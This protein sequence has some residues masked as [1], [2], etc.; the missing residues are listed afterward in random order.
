M[1]ADKKTADQPAS[2][3]DQHR[4]FTPHTPF[5]LPKGA[6]HIRCAKAPSAGRLS[7]K[8]DL[9]IP[10]FVL[11]AILAYFALN[12]SNSQLAEPTYLNRSP[13]SRTSGP[14]LCRSS[15]SSRSWPSS[16][17]KYSLAKRM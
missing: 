14:R 8:P 10:H 12:T 1:A 13:W 3:I 17:W 2:P 15:T 16:N 9:P 11:F 4:L 5:A 7:A 6:R